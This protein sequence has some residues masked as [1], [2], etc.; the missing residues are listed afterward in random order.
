MRPKRLPALGE[1]LKA[2]ERSPAPQTLRLLLRE[3][4]DQSTEAL[5]SFVH[6]GIHPLRRTSDGLRV[7]LLTHGVCFSNALA[8]LTAM[9]LATLSG[10]ARRLRAV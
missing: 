6:G 10:D 5:N 3:F 2:L 1:M 7:E 9:L 4:S 8:H